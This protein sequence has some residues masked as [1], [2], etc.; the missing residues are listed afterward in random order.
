MQIRFATRS[1]TNEFRGSSYFYLQHHK[2]NAN[3][4]FNNRDRA[5]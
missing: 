4:W 5:G 1:G 2:L 3:S